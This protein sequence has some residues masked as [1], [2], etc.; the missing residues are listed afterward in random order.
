MSLLRPA[1]NNEYADR[2]FEESVDGRGLPYVSCYVLNES[3]LTFTWFS[4]QI[5]EFGHAACRI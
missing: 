4:G 5:G 2:Q 1:F 3:F